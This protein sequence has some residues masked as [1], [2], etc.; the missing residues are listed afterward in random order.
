MAMSSS[1]AELSNSTDT[2]VQDVPARDKGSGVVL[3]EHVLENDMLAKEAA[4]ASVG[5]PLY[6]DD[7]ILFSHL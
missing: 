7:N 1:T 2:N 4:I 5:A 3:E 6:I